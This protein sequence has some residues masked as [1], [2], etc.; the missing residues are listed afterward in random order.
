MLLYNEKP[1]MIR[2]LL[3]KIEGFANTHWTETS[4]S[5][6]NRRTSSYSAHEDYLKSTTVLINYGPGETQLSIGHH[7]FSF[8]FPLPS[9]IPSTF[10]SFYGEIVYQVKVEMD[11]S[12]KFNYTFNFPFTVITHLDLNYESVELKRPLKGETSKK[13][14]LGF[15]SNALSITA[16]I[17]FC[18]FVAGQ[19]LSVGVKIVNDTSVK[20]KQVLVELYR[21]CHFKCDFI[22]TKNDSQLLVKG[23][24]KGIEA[25]ASDQLTFSLQIPAVEPTN[26]RYCKYIFTNYELVVTA[27][28]GGMHHS[29]ILKM[30]IT[31]GTVPFN[32]MQTF[33]ASTTSIGFANFDAKGEEAK[34]N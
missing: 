17:P 9:T 32:D 20:V 34:K 6:D 24:Y 2:A 15:G 30:P 29:P 25:K 22:S 10:K 13:F 1:R 4:G 23:E 14:F 12:L 33:G 21:L 31:I 16:E 7:T 5:D 3:L 26:V 8:S 18:G 28:V 27:K 11:R 19:I